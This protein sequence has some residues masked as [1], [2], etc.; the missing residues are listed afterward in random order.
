MI[1]IE[2]DLNKIL[3]N[4]NQTKII[5]MLCQKLIFFTVQTRWKK[6]MN[7]KT[8]LGVGYYC[9]LTFFLLYCMR[10]LIPRV[11]NR[12]ESNRITLNCPMTML[13]KTCS[14][15]NPCWLVQSLKHYYTV[16]MYLPSHCPCTSPKAP[17]NLG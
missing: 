1:G 4:S 10:K 3:R 15:H 12:Q 17:W 14:Q 5:K 9:I 13:T 11:D 2:R 7:T 6:C 8:A 16:S